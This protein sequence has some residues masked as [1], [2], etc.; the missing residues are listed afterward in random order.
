[1]TFAVFLDIEQRLDY[2]KHLFHNVADL[3]AF[4]F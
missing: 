1:M 4:N 2:I 3:L